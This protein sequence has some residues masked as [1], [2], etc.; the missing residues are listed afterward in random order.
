[1]TRELPQTE[2]HH[3][4]DVDMGGVPTENDASAPK[5]STEP[6]TSSQ[7]GAAKTPGLPHANTF[8]CTPGAR[9]PLEDLIGNFDEH[10]RRPEPE[11]KS[12]EEQLGW[13]PNSSSTLLTPNRRR[14]RARSSSPSC[15]TTSSQRQESTY[16]AGN[17]TQGEEKTPE[18][19]P[20]AD[21]WRRYGDDKEAGEGL[22]LPDI[23]HLMGQAS[24][25]PL[26]TPAKSAAFRRW[27]STGNDWPS[28]KNKRRR[29]D[30]RSNVAVW[31]DAQQ[32]S[33]GSVGKGTVASMVEKLQET[34]A[35]NRI[36]Q[37]AAK[38]V[39][40]VQAPSSSSPLPGT[41][42]EVFIRTGQQTSP[43]QA[44]QQQQRPGRSMHMAPLQPQA[45]KPLEPFSNVP[46]GVGGHAPQAQAA[47][48]FK[49]APLHLQSKAP[50]PAFRKPAMSR[51]L[52]A[53]GRQYPQRQTPQPAPAPPPALPAV[54]ED[55]DEF[56]EEFDLSAEDLEELV[57]Q[58]PL[59]ERSL[60][61]IPPH[62]NPPPQ[63]RTSFDHQTPAAPS[64]AHQQATI[65]IDDDDEFGG[66]D[67][68]EGTLVQAELSATQAY[69]ASQPS[70]RNIA[71]VR[72]K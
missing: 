8:P 12:P 7:S 21:L 2:V 26:E 64:P 47:E 14:K 58:K 49:P 60:H 56:G 34:L 27:A 42:T 53:S 39:A 15:P 36:A 22:K 46:S 10:A 33:E 6:T 13:I 1:M 25:R 67:L 17:A 5:H 45:F 57:S 37:S 31:R 54:Q 66:D 23:S 40:E 61:E 41:G 20:A 35:S 44:R 48:T 38:Q 68:D 72:S 19:D 3:A 32:Q 63:Q 16:F 9:I 24:P 51:P 11:V 65:S 52:S 62:P 55:L 4:Q 18:A 71:A 29:V 70:S 59:G 50:L 28:S 43:L 69:R 30:G